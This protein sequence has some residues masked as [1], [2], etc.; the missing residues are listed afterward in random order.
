MLRMKL[1][2]KPAVRNEIRSAGLIQKYRGV[3]EPEQ[4]QYG[5]NGKQPDLM[6]SFHRRTFPL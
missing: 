6:F 3:V 5:D 1:L 2:R 4:G